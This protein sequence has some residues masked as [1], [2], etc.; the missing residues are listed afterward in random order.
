VLPVTL[1][2]I[3]NLFSTDDKCR[4]LLERL[5]WSDVPQCPRCEGDKL[6]RLNAKLLYCAKCDYQFSVTA[7]TIFND[8]HLPLSKWFVAVL[9]L[10][11]ARKGF[12][13]NQMKRTLGVKK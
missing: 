11:E 12:S 1:P 5:R 8:S 9:L 7:G 10:V 13:A 2:E 4:E 6:A 3:T